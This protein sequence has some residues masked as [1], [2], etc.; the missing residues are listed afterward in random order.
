MHVYKYVY[1]KVICS[2]CTFFGY[3]KYVVLEKDATFIKS[4]R[5]RTIYF[6][7]L[8]KIIYIYKF[9]VRLPRI[10]FFCTNAENLGVVCKISPSGKFRVYPIEKINIRFIFSLS[11]M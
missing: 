2:Y 10:R 5:Y 8:K 7:A 3:L 9:R 4:I 1:K 6:H 11:R